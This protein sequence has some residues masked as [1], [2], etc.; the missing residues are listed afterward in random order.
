MSYT[1]TSPFRKYKWYV[2]HWRVQL[3]PRLS[4]QS[5][6]FSKDSLVSGCQTSAEPGS[7]KTK[8]RF[9]NL[10]YFL[11]YLISSNIH[12]FLFVLKIVVGMLRQKNWRLPV[13]YKKFTNFFSENHVRLLSYLCTFSDI[14]N[15]KVFT[16]F[17][18]GQTYHKRS[19]WASHHT[20]VQ[21]KL[22]NI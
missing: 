22:S 17:I 5:L 6:M 19:I 1:V 4:I 12:F 9:S 16:G 21:K 13:F 10:K 15:L 7:N 11:E 8:L 18:S 14:H 2:Q 20:L 3:H